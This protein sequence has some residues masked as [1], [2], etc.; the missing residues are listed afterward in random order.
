MPLKTLHIL[1][2]YKGD[3]DTE[4]D[5]LC[6][7]IIYILYHYVEHIHHY[8]KETEFVKL[9]PAILEKCGEI[10]GGLRD[11]KNLPNNLKIMFLKKLDTTYD[12]FYTTSSYS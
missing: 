8:I 7:T 11:N 3:V 12:T 2:Q 4:G 10:K 5:I 6:F 1:L 9:I